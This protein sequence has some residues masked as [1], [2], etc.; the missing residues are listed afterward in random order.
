MRSWREGAER[1]R[2]AGV[3]SPDAD[4]RLLLAHVLEVPLLRLPIAGE[5]D[6]EQRAAYVALIE[7][8]AAREP[9]QHLTGTAPFRRVELAVGP[10]VFVPRPE[11]ELLA[12]WAVAQAQSVRDADGRDPVVVDL[13]TGSGAIARAVV[14]EVEGV[15]VH[16][17]E[18]DEAAHAWAGRNLAGTGVDLRLGDLAEAFGDLDGEVDVVVSNP[19]Y[20]PTTAWESVAPEARDH[21]P[22]TALWSGEDGLDAI[23]AVERRAAALLRPG[24]VVGVE[25]ADAQGEAAPAV[26]AATGRW[27][28]VRDH[29]DLAGRARFVTARLVRRDVPGG[30]A[31]EG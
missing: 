14:D 8:R 23:R 12:G 22:A 10:G 28:E 20:I 25:H 9:L 13:G 11:T 31:E 2:A 27:A 5:P 7:R 21:D 30:A 18:V 26:L 16:A 17:V 1:L 19:P 29:D 3:A 24:G 15:R 4:A 6:A